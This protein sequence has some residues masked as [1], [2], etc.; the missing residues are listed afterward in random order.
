MRNFVEAVILGSSSGTKL[1]DLPGQALDLLPV[2]VCICDIDG[3][4][5]R[6]NRRAAE[7]WGRHPAIGDRSSRFCGASRLYSVEGR[8][9]AHCDGP[10]GEFLRTFIPVRN[11]EMLV[12]RPDG[13]RRVVLANVDALEDKLGRRIGAIGCFQDLTGY[14]SVHGHFENGSAAASNPGAVRAAQRLAAIVD[15]SEDA[16]ISKDL[17]GIIES[18]NASAERLFGYRADEVIGQPIKIIIPVD[19]FEEET[20]ILGR[21]RRG[22]RINHFE[23]VRMRKDGSP[24]EISLTVSPVL[25]AEGKVVGASKIARDVTELRRARAQQHLLLREMNHR[26]RNLFALSSGV[27]SLSARTATTIQDLVGSVRDRLSALARAHALTLPNLGTGK[28]VEQATTLYALV[29]AILSPFGPRA[30]ESE[31]LA[32][33][34]PDVEIS[35]SSVTSLALLLHEFATNAA[36]YG[37]LSCPEGSIHIESSEQG[38]DLLLVWKEIGG[39]PVARLSENE[40]FGSLL[41][42]TTVEGHLAGTLSREWHP[43]GLEIRLTVS[44]DKL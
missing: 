3:Q 17:D 25:D 4:I 22:E 12:G 36:K 19:R 34:G 21:I 29:Q 37:A 32:I 16:I 39:P 23:T 18:W 33:S 13:S 9:I 15:S 28:D 1:S 10:I 38:D 7:L 14:R 43:D 26:I 30:G 5:I 42:R 27:V 20:E 41:V 44:R 8:S 2:A 11:R 31:R 40:G 24:I 6:Y 35:E